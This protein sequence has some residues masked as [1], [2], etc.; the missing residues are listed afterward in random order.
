[1]VDPREAVRCAYRAAV[2]SLEE[3]GAW[4][5][6]DTRTPR[7]HLRLLPSGHR[8]RAIFADVAG[9]FEGVWFG[10][11]TPTSDDARMVLSRLEELG[12]LRAE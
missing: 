5:A 12:C 8:R 2:A 6:D 3:E 1:M 4:R 7:E 9:R 10:G 11:R